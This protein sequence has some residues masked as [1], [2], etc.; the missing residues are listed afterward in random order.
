MR[1]LRKSQLLNENENHLKE[2]DINLRSE[3]DSLRAILLAKV[4]DVE[5]RE[6]EETVSRDAFLV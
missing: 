3:L 2:S 6:Q 4:G 5:G 1:I